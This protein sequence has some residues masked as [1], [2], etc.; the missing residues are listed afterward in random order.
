MIAQITVRSSTVTITTP[1]GWT[2]IRTDVGTNITQALYYK[3][4]LDTES[5]P[6]WTFS[7]SSLR[8]A[9]GIIVLRGTEL[10]APIIASQSG[11][12]G[13][14]TSIIAPSVDTTATNSMIVGFFGTTD[15][16]TS[17]TI[18][19]GTTNSFANQTGTSS[20]GVSI[21]AA[22]SILAAIGASGDWTATG[23]SGAANIGQ[24]VAIRPA[25]TSCVV[26]DFNR[27]SL[28][29][30]WAVA[31]SSGSF[32][33]PTIISNRL[34]LT[35]AS[36][37]VATAASLQRI[38]PAAGNVITAEFDYYAYGGSG[39]DGIATIFSDFGTTPQPGAYGGSLGYAQKT[40]ING[41][42]GGWLGIGIDEYGNYSNSTEGRNGNISG[43]A[44]GLTTNA[45]AIRGSGSAT[46]GYSYLAGT[47]ALSKVSSGNSTSAY[48]YRVT[49]DSRIAGQAW[50]SVDRDTAGGTSYTN[51][52]PRFN[53][54][55]SSGQA[56]APTNIVF[57]YTGSTGG[58]TNI[59]EIDNLN[60]CSLNV[61]QT[62]YT[63]DH[64]RFLHDGTGQA[65]QPET[66]R[67]LACKD[68]SCSQ[69]YTGSVTATFSPTGWVGGDTKTFT[70][71]TA[72]LQYQTNVAGTITLGTTSS[73]PT[74]KPF[75]TP[76]CF[77]NT[78]GASRACTITF[79]DTTNFSFA[80][81]TQTAGQNSSAVTITASSSSCSGG[82]PPSFKNVVRTVNFWSSYLNPSTGTLK[83][84]MD[85]YEKTD[86]TNTAGFN[87]LA[88]S[89]ASPT[90]LS[91]YFNN[92]GVG[93]FLLNYLDVGLLKLDA[94]YTGSSANGD[95]GLSMAGNS[96]FVVKPY[97]FALSNIIRTSDS[98]ANPAAANAS[99]TAFIK[100][101][102]PFSVTVTAKALGGTTTPNYGKES[103][104]E[105]IKLTPTLVSGLGLTNNPAIG[106]TT[107]FGAF[108]SGV[109]TGTDFTWG[110]V[111]IFT[112]TPSVTDGDYLGVGDVTGTISGNVG[113]FIPDHFGYSGATVTNRS[114]ASCSTASSFTYMGEPFDTGFTLTAQNLSNG[115]TQ[116]YVGAF[117]KLTL[118]T[119]S[120]FGFGAINSAATKTPLTS[121]LNLQSSS[122][123][124]TSGIA[125]VTA[126]AS[127]NRAASP[128]GVF[129]N[130]DFGIA[131]TDSDGVTLVPTPPLA[132]PYNLD[133]D[134]NS[135]ND[136]VKLFTSK[137][138][139]GRV[140]LSNAFGSELVRLPVSLKAEYY[141]TGV[142]WVQNTDDS[143][144]ALTGTLTLSNPTRNMT[145]SAST[146][147]LSSP[148]VQGNAN[149]FLSAPGA[150]KNGSIDLTVNAPA[151]LK[152]DW[153]TAV[154][155]DENPTSRAIFGI[156]KNPVI[157][158]RENY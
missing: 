36:G 51:L 86:G 59:H 110:E 33:S 102:N 118:T 3:A 22:S 115:T 149:L 10:V 103:P 117:S 92:S 84:N 37:N 1:A 66:I 44:S 52:V 96:Q 68:P 27:T 73:T 107:G 2:L 97:T 40:G 42:A 72:T 130:F 53:A 58:S 9:G 116:N 7:V 6:N 140:R 60:I 61:Q 147:S 67:V 19:S 152:Y 90:A 75:S 80:V 111:G 63:I 35:D 104:A 70:G 15:G 122:G 87:A 17:V 132:N 143:C 18:P 145:T 154:A 133:V 8:R 65:C 76:Q 113:R 105:G 34:R 26:D 11:A 54:L 55:A 31:S 89:S 48:K 14:G 156:F 119:P 32:G 78:T 85:A 106:F 146:A 129:D 148:V 74:L 43:N 142:G 151:W 21:T 41:F 94:K 131:P 135:T 157:Y 50:V 144:T 30:D 69:L 93:Q 13:S 39:A 62:S 25:V 29:T 24:L 127:L 141:N 64:F 79:T 45:V 139:Y 109:A 128:D 95:A 57:S 88:T 126:R 101:G 114:T 23:S 46:T 49:I 98:F 155:G 5:A 47:S 99:G 83:L 71:G 158:Q 138:R 123:T 4:A 136:H 153:N 81:P 20:T 91:V 56:A 121:R 77:D 125:A 12:S 124:W 28:G 100:A 120:V 134:N 137:I 112:L 150:G 108:S 38:F 16:G 82:V